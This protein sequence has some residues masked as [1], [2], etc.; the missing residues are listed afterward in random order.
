MAL[1]TASALF[2]DSLI[3][4]TATAALGVLLGT[5]GIDVNSGVIRFDF[6]QSALDDGVN[7]VAVVVGLFAFADVITHVGALDKRVPLTAKITGLLPTKAYLKASS[8]AI[9]RDTAFRC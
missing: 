2:S 3:K 7:F 9:L 6:G 4:T 1:V 5:V 8:P